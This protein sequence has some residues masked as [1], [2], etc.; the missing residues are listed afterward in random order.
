MRD[1]ISLLAIM[2]NVWV[3]LPCLWFGM[4]GMAGA[5]A[6]ISPAE[7][8]I[9]GVGYLAISC[10]IAIPTVFWFRSKT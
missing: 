6:D 9:Y 1:A 8:R 7:N 2:L 5:L 3:G 4:I 10:L